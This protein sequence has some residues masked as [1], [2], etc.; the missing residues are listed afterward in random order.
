MKRTK[1]CSRGM[2]VQSIMF[3]KLQW[4]PETA[5]EWLESHDHAGLSVDAKGNYLRFRQITP[6][7][8]A[9]GSFRTVALSIAK[10]IKAIVCCPKQ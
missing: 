10:H 6:S 7:K 4:T 5:K 8:C 9:R 2:K 3:S 1:K